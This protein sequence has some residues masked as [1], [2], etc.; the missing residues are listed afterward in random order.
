MFGPGID[1]RAVVWWLA[2][3]EYFTVAYNAGYPPFMRL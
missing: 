3:L 1:S 2:D